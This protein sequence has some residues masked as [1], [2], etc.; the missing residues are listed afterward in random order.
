MRLRTK[1]GLF[2]V[3]VLGATLVLQRCNRPN[4]FKGPATITNDRDTIVVHRKGRPDVNIFQPD[5]GSTVITTDDKGNVTVKVRQLGMGFDPGWGIGL[6]SRPRAALDARI[7]YFK[8][9]GLN[10]GFG[11]SLDRDDYRGGHLLDVAAPYAGIGYV[12]LFRFP[13]TSLVVSYAMD[14]HAFVF[15]RT[16]F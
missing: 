6:S 12:P 4:V 15:V 9:F 10:V 14:G 3:G 16:G 8:R 1:A 13:N 11:I 7:A 2:V 5:P